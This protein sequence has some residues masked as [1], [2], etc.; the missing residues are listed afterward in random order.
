MIRDS[1]GRPAV[2]LRA[3]GR[4]ARSRGVHGWAGR[5]LV[6]GSGKGLV[7]LELKPEQRA[8][9]LGV[10]VRLRELIVSVEDPAALI[11]SLRR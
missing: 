1:S 10:P 3:S 5:W 4:I 9:V 2:T 8:R 11:R 7:S 6:N